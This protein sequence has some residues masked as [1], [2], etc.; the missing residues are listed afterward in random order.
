MNIY[1]TGFL[2]ALD[3]SGKCEIFT[4]KIPLLAMS[5]MYSK[6]RNIPVL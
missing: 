3:S 4:T 1:I 6:T 5:H 2:E